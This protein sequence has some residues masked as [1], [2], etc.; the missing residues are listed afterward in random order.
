MDEG[1]VLLKDWSIAWRFV[2]EAKLGFGEL[3]MLSYMMAVQ[4]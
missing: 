2:F 1:V 4:L 3:F